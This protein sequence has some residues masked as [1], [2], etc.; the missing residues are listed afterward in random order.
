MIT[1]KV[2]DLTYTEEEGQQVFNGTRKQ[3]V[4]FVSEQPLPHQYEIVPL[5]ERCSDAS[6][7]LQITWGILSFL[8]ILS[9]T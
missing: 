3:C 5:G 4:S 1:H 2:L 8:I 7:L 6:N 9:R